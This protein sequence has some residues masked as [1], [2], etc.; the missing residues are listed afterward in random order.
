MSST[1]FT[2]FGADIDAL[3]TR[4]EAEFGAS[5]VAYIKRVA[6][7]SR[8]LEVIGRCLIHFSLE[9]LSFGLGVLALGAHKQLH[10]SEIGHA[11][12][13]G[14]YDRLPGAEGFRSKGY[15][16]EMPIDEESW[17]RGHNIRHHQY[18]NVAGRDP[19]CRYGTVRLNDRVEYRDENRYQ[20][21]HPLVIWPTFSFN[22]AMHFSGMIDLYTRKPGEWD[23]IEDRSKKTIIETHRRA[24]RKAVPYYAKEYLLFPALAGPM[25]WKVALGNWLAERLRSIYSA[26]TIFCGHVGEDTRAYEPHERAKSRA[27][28]YAMQ[29][30]A[31]RNF[32]VPKP[33]SILCGGLDLQIEHHLFPKWPPNRLREVAPQVRAI[34]ERHGVRYQSDAWGRTLLSV[35][36]RLRQLSRPPE[37]A[38]EAAPAPEPTRK[39]A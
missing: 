38:P 39:A 2:A 9:P 5:D 16:W 29:V 12:L 8:G 23:V 22:M 32:E 7:I 19:D 17:H 25:F 36:R 11:V 33:I 10:G 24:L 14:A 31:A 13:H 27:Q 28:W 30:E 4:V 26:A 18:T 15:W 20:W 37:V 21:L 1:D 35:F 3:R 34:C 6:R